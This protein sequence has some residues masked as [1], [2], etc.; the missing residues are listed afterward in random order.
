VE[1]SG[2]IKEQYENGRIYYAL[3]GQPLVQLPERELE[4]PS[5]EFIEWHNNNVY[6]G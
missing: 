5:Q 2:R 6:A 4:R 3:H 1:V